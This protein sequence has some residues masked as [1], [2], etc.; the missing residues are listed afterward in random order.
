MVLGSVAP[1]SVIDGGVSADIVY[2]GGLRRKLE[3]ASHRRRKSGIWGLVYMLAPRTLAVGVVLTRVLNDERVLGLML[4]MRL[5]SSFKAGALCEQGKGD[6]LR[7]CLKADSG[8]AHLFTRRQNRACL[9][10]QPEQPRTTGS[11]HTK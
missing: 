8:V 11:S 5:H 1:F 6:A 7:G 9:R 4:L 2:Y 3:G 10:Q